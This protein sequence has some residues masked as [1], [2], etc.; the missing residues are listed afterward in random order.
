MGKIQEVNGKEN[1][2]LQYNESYLED[3]VRDGFYI[4]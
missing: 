4:P 3:E 1:Y 2:V